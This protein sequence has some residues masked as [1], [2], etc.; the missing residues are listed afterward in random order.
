LNTA[1]IAQLLR[2]HQEEAGLTAHEVA[3]R[4][5][6][7]VPEATQILAGDPN[8][9]AGLLVRV[10]EALGCDLLAVPAPS[11]GGEVRPHAKEPDAG[12]DADADG[13]AGAAPGSRQPRIAFGLLAEQ[14]HAAPDFDGPLRLEP[15][16]SDACRGDIGQDNYAYSEAAA[17]DRRR[18]ARRLALHEAA[19]REL[20]ARPKRAED[21]LH[22][23]ECWIKDGF[24]DRQLA[25]DWR[26]VVENKDWA[27][28]MELSEHGKR[29]R[30]GSPFACLVSRAERSAIFKHFATTDGLRK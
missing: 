16:S 18:E 22:I 24:P 26:R 3:E 15:E 21:V 20:R 1:D 19:V 27:K 6:C 2:H 5:G 10:C 13:D 8:A 14:V 23:L 28:L 12:A 25:E 11:L 17:Q 4:A 29:L 30:K 7:S 9:P